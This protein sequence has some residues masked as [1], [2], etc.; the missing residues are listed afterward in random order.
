[1]PATEIRLDHL[2]KD[3]DSVCADVKE[4]KEIDLPNIHRE[5]QDLKTAIKIYG[6]L[7]MGGITVLIG[8]AIR[9]GVQ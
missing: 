2:E 1:M 9:G 7:V 5:M 6:S 3:M 4:I 8:L